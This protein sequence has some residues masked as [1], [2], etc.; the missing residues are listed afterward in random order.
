MKIMGIDEKH[1][2]MVGEGGQGCFAYLMRRQAKDGRGFAIE[3]FG[4]DFLAGKP[5]GVAIL[6]G[7]IDYVQNP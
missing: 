1:L 7:M 6:D 4:L 2:F 5:E 3:S